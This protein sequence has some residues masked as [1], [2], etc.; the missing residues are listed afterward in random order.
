MDVIEYLQHCIKTDIRPS[1]IHGIGTFALRDIEVGETL[2]ELW[3]GD[4]K[5][6]TIEKYEFEKLPNHIKKLI[7][8]GYLNKPDYPLV[9]FRLFKDCY[10]NLANPI[11]HTNTAEKDGNFDSVTKKVIK[12]IKAGEEILGTYNLN[13]TILK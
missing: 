5:I 12:P 1:Q 6:Y 9:W 13:N 10:W 2:F 11:T 3:E 8:K 4:T 7:L